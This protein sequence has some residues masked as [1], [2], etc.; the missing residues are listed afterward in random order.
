MVH[1]MSMGL[2][3]PRFHSIQTLIPLG[4]PSVILQS[5]SS[6]AM[7]ARAECKTG[8]DLLSVLI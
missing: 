2:K 8:M 3:I 7:R 4:L 6:S 1:K 5:A